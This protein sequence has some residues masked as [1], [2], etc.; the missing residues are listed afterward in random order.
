[1]LLATLFY[2]A[3][4]VSPAVV[5][6]L[7]VAPP[8]RGLLECEQDRADSTQSRI[9]TLPTPSIMTS[10]APA[11]P[12]AGPRQLQ[13][14]SARFTSPKQLT[15]RSS[16]HAATNSISSSLNPQA[17][18]LF[19]AAA[20]QKISSSHHGSH[21]S[22]Q[23]SRHTSAKP[24]IDMHHSQRPASNTSTL[25]SAIDVTRFHPASE[26]TFDKDTHQFT[27]DSATQHPAAAVPHSNGQEHYQHSSTQG[28]MPSLSFASR[29]ASAGN[30]RQHN[31]YPHEIA[32]KASSSMHQASSFIKSLLPQMSTNAEVVQSAVSSITHMEHSEHGKSNQAQQPPTALRILRDITVVAAAAAALY[33][34]S[35]Y[36]DQLRKVT[37]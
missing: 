8:E 20:Y 18:P 4:C 11:Q 25:T 30:P 7:N 14:S 23:N 17:S 2:D 33:S 31:P 9:A 13:A 28:H 19:N 34:G 35:R 5:V 10:T 3:A 36:I 27:H 21:A 26:L 12:S 24:S 1:M 16:Q 29:S 6:L 15:K 32:A 37:R 22:S